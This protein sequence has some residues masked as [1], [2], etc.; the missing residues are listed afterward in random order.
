MFFFFQAED[1]IRD[2]GVTGVQTCALPISQDDS[3]T[4]GWSAEAGAASECRNQRGANGVSDWAT[5]T[6][7]HS[8]DLSSEPDGAYTFR[9]RA[10][11][12]AGNTGADAT[13]AYTLDRTA[14]AAP[15]ITSGPA[16]D[17][18]DDSPSYGFTAEVGAALECRI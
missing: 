18:T 14:P 9:V 17:S 8:Y 1:G 13:R 4:Y 10:V 16:A 11:D 2:I 15:T 5:C 6:S 7:T 3:P 12:A